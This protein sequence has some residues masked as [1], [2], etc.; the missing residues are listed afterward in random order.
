MLGRTCST[1]IGQLSRER[2]VPK[3]VSRFMSSSRSGKKM[4][5]PTPSWNVVCSFLHHFFFV[6][7]V[8]FVCFSFVFSKTESK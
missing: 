4:S 5:F 1:F 6:C 7:F 3:T 2:A 8:G